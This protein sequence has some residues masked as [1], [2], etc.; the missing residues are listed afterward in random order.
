MCNVQLPPKN[1]VDKM[2][3]MHFNFQKSYS[4]VCPSS[5]CVLTIVL[6]NFEK[7]NVKKQ[8]VE[9]Q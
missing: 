7:Q 5:L 6:Q 1:L 2:T 3:E 9:K 8:N 4:S